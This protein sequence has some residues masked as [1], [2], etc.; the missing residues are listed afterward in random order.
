MMGTIARLLDEAYVSLLVDTVKSPEALRLDLGRVNG[1]YWN[2][3]EVCSESF[4]LWLCDC[5]LHFDQN[6]SNKH[7]SSC[8]VAVQTQVGPFSVLLVQLMLTV[9]RNHAPTVGEIQ[10]ISSVHVVYS[11]H[12]VLE[13]DMCMPSMIEIDNCMYSIR[14]GGGCSDTRSPSDSLRCVSS[15]APPPPQTWRSPHLPFFWH[16][17][18]KNVNAGNE[19]E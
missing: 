2:L 3:F 13:G 17:Q 9:L 14:H 18:W 7:W 12:S 16:T 8:Y 6:I 5:C 4:S 11:H 1:I 19:G 15:R 10:T